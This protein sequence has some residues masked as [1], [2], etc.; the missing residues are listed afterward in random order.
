MTMHHIN[1][2]EVSKDAILYLSQMTE[3]HF[4]SISLSSS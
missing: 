1:K 4:S 2:Q 3:M